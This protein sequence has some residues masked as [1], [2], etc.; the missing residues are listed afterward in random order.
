MTRSNLVGSGGSAGAEAA[1]R[2]RGA[3]ANRSA[4]TSVPVTAREQLAEADARALLAAAAEELGGG[5]STHLL[6]SGS[7][8]RSFGVSPSKP[9]QT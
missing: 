6:L 5:V 1:Q 3:T 9:T 8:P 4:L 2:A 7:R